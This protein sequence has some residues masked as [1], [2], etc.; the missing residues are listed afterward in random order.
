M[1]R[2]L[3]AAVP[4]AL[5]LAVLVAAADHPVPEPLKKPPPAKFEC[6]WADTPIT[7]DGV[8][9]EDAWKHAQEVTAFHLPWLGDGARMARTRTAAKLLWDREHLYFFAEMEDSDL[10]ADVKDRDGDT[11]KNDVFEL[12]FR[13]AADKAGYYEFQVSAAGTVFDAFYPKWDP[14]AIRKHAKAADFRLDAKVKLRGTLNQRGDADTGWTV[15]GRLPWTD[16]ARTGGRPVPGEEW[17]LNLCRY[18]Y[19]K[20]W[21]APELSCVAPI[22]KRVLPA[23]FHQ[24]D[25][26][27]TVT[28]VAADAATAKP[29]GIETYE[30]VR[31]STVVGFPDPPP[32]YRAAR[33]LPDFRPE[34]P[35]QIAR[36]PGSTDALLL[37]QPR[38]Y[39]PTTLHRVSLAAGAKEATKL[40]DTPDG[41]TAYDLAFHPK[42]A[43]NGF[44]YVGWN[45]KATDGGK[46]KRS[47]VT[48]YTMATKPPFAV[49]EKTAKTV[50][51]WESDGHNG[52]AV[53]FGGDGMMYVTSGDGTSDSDTNVTGQR[54]D[55]MLAKVLRIDVD[56]PAADKP[57]SVPKDN[58][59]GGDKRFAPETWA[60]G[61]RNPWRIT[62]DAKTDQLWVGNNGQ[63]LWE[64]AYLVR[65]GDN[66]GWSV[67]E[68]S[69]DFYPERKLGPTP[70]VNPT[71][72][73]HHSEARSLTGGVVYHGDKLPDLKGAYVYG[74]YSTGR[75]W[76]AK[77]DG[78]K[79]VSHREVASTNLK[80][81]CFALDAAGELLIGHHAGKGDGGFFTLEPN[82]EKAAGTFPKKL[83]DSGLFDSVKG[84]KL[85]PGV[86]P[87]SVNAPF[88]SDGL[89][90]ERAVM[91]PPGETIGFTRNRAWNFP[92]KTVIVKSFA[93]EETEGDPATRRWVETRFMTKQGGEWY[94]YSYEWDADGTDAALV[95][96]KGLDR[97]FTVKTA[98]GERKQAWHYP[99][100]AECMVCHSRAQN[101]VLGLC[102]LQAN[103]DHTYPSGRTDNQLRVFEHLGLLKV[104]WY[105]EAK[106]GV[107]GAGNAPQ[108]DQRAAKPGPLLHQPPAAFKRLV[109]PYDAAQDLDARARSYLHAN[110]ASCHV[111]AG[112]GNAQ[113]E[114]E[115]GTTLEKTR[116]VGAAPV[117]QG[118]GLADPKLVAPGAPERSVLVHR[119]GL[120]GPGQMPPLSS[121]RVDEAGA[122][123]L[124]DWVKAMK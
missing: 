23:F 80:I 60:Y 104:D 32:P 117:H 100:R 59:F 45:G 118:F 114:A 81:T 65:K 54:T 51:E 86:V 83:S 46:G 4:A 44:V 19:H 26:Y 108:P 3:A 63:D 39:G 96:A 77:H 99:S 85:K 98:G 92:D 102:E 28:F 57:Y 112:G 71:V 106:G 122:A 103:K 18:D 27:A 89:Y 78:A 53:C 42:F 111:G 105:A 58:P 47:R 94:G 48:R 37:T 121:S 69:H 79:L 43:E 87:Y 5:G 52:A 101:F 14:D 11:W 61:L 6:R 50:I 64:Q 33:A 95:D 93:V 62:F 107:K 25:D 116:L 7:L 124:R 9:D 12:F 84:H 123:L 88:W 38:S 66:Y 55:L 30:P 22:K 115:F 70:A 110:C 82:P 109:D 36:I 31:T 10:F 72:E 75:V 68:G 1:R 2:T 56:R 29:F 113:F 90:K 20:D 120:R 13:P 15:E 67:K 119:V 8:A 91:V 49:D 21:A 35:V 24:T 41:G 40:F 97:T 34:Y 74:D 17:K 73:H 76:A 16:F